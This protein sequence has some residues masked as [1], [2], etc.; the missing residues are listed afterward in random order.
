VR[1]VRLPASGRTL[2]RGSVTDITERKRAEETRRILESRLA[3]AQKMEAV[4]RLAGG[5][6]HDFNNLLTVIIGYCE[7][8]RATG[9]LADAGHDMVEG[10]CAASERA[11]ALT[12]QLLTFSRQQVV[13][14]CVL[15]LNAVVA[16]TEKMLRRLIGEDIRLETVL[17]PALAPVRADPGQIGQVI[18]N[19]AVNA[20]DA[21]PS[22]GK[23]TIETA[24]V[25]LDETFAET[26][27]GRYVL[28][29]VT[30]TGQGMTPE[31]KA[32]VFEPFFTTKGS[33]R[34]TGLGLATVRTIAEQNRGFVAVYS[35]PGRGSTFKVY[36]PTLDGSARVEPA[37]LTP[38]GPVGGTETILLVEDEDAVRAVTRR[39]LQ[40]LGYTV[41]EASG[42]FEAL[43]WAEQFAGTIDLLVT[44]VV[45]PDLGGRKLVEE[46]TLVRPGLKVLYLSGYTDDAVVRHGVL[47]ADVAFLQKPFTVEALARKVR[48]TLA[49]APHSRH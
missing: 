17:Q 32:R 2:I 25:E 39:I 8:L 48:Q 37:G 23:L 24:T 29:A 46:L 18:M 49:A 4:G 14:P 12:R 13:E 40:G 5:V 38:G 7:L 33:G 30:D 16:D 35:E 1:L 20:R 44:D 15:D 6:A 26:R 21:M 42:G 9:P 19:L 11:A 10:I 3:Q 41:V 43:R 27:P 45:M 47:H 28:L 34:G 22:G 31:V 36:L